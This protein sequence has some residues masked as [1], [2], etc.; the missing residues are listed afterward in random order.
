MY[1]LV[2]LWWNY[3]PVVEVFWSVPVSLYEV[4]SS[5]L[6]SPLGRCFVPP[7]ART[8]NLKRVIRL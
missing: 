1:A 8:A 3:M 4:R 7:K 5:N 2:V 6:F